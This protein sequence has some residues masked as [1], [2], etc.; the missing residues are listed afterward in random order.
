M[1]A[2]VSSPV[3]YSSSQ[4]RSVGP[5]ARGNGCS[6]AIAAARGTSCRGPGLRRAGSDRRAAPQLSEARETRNRQRVNTW[7]AGAD[8]ETLAERPTRATLAARVADEIERTGIAS[9]RSIDDFRRDRAANNPVPPHRRQRQQPA[10]Y[11]AAP[12]L[13][14]NQA[15]VR[16]PGPYAR[17]AIRR[18]AYK[19]TKRELRRVL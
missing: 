19:S 6:A 9:E 2:L 8:V 13:G 18:P 11:R 7:R 5:G 15:A 17:R 16:G 10:L 4:M 14:Y 1:A 3:L 12:D